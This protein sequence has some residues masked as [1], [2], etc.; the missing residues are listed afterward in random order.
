MSLHLGGHHRMTED[1]DYMLKN[2]ETLLQS[3]AGSLCIAAYAATCPS[4]RISS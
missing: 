4:S 1:R 3:E 2:E